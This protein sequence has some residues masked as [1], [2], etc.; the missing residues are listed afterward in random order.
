GQCRLR[1]ADAML[2]GDARYFGRHHC[3]RPRMFSCRQWIPGNEH[4]LPLL[5][6]V[7]DALRAA[8]VG[9][10]AVLYGRDLYDPLGAAQLLEADIRDADVTDLAFLLQLCELTEGLLDRYLRIDG[11]E[12]V[13][14]DAIHA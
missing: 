6:V 12:L 4:D 11:M 9:V 1:L 5:T 10:V 13:E 3:L 2:A 8:V 14:V 7:D